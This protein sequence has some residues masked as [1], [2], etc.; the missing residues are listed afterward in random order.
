MRVSF[1]TLRTP[2]ASLPR[3]AGIKN[4]TRTTLLN[5]L[6]SLQTPPHPA[7]IKNNTCT[8][9]ASSNSLH[10]PQ[11]HTTTTLRVLKIIPTL[12]QKTDDLSTPP[13]TIPIHASIKNNTRITLLQPCS[14]P[15]TSGSTRTTA[16]S[17][18]SFHPSTT[19]NHHLAGIKNNTHIAV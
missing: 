2:S 19:H 14:L 8:S 4:N 17:S 7:G 6:A 9:A 15:R 10:S 11:P 5:P 13:L 12:W 16:A 18:N 3:L 1:H